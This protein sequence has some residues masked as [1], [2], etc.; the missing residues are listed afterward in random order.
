MAAS[1]G[2]CWRCVCG[3]ASQEAGWGIACCELCTVVMLSRFPFSGADA[4]L[5]GD[6]ARRTSRTTSQPKSSS[7]T[8]GLAAC[9]A[10]A[11]FGM[12]ICEICL[13]G[14]LVGRSWSIDPWF[15]DRS[16]TDLSFVD[17]HLINP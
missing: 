7:L 3:K 11:C 8:S 1:Y 5:G 13:C 17:L 14:C 12:A 9:Y 15:V 2:V 16:S 6:Q 4:R 10:E